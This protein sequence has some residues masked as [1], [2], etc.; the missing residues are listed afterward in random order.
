MAAH[1]TARRRQYGTGSV[2]QRASDGRWIGQL[3]VGL[4]PRGTNR[5]VTVSNYP[6]TTVEITKAK[7]TIAGQPRLVGE[8][9]PEVFVPSS[10][11]FLF[12]SV[13]SYMNSYAGRQM[14]SLAG[15]SPAVTVNVNGDINNG[16]DTATLAAFI[17]QTVS[18]A[19]GGI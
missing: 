14:S 6:G 7:T 4:T 13:S 3:L 1:V 16:M 9:R 19:L 10:N 12:P 15:N 11:G 17:N 18:Q 2:F 8:K 5:Y